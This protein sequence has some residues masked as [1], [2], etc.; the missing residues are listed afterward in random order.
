MEIRDVIH[1]LREK[2]LEHSLAIQSLRSNVEM[3]ERFTWNLLTA[4]QAE[5]AVTVTFADP[6]EETEDA[7][8]PADPTLF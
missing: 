1:S 6:E 4:L 2:S 3:L 7:P 8:P 5:G